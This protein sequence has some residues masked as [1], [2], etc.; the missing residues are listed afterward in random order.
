MQLNR[1]DQYETVADKRLK[2]RA[3]TTEEGAY[4]SRGI[5]TS[6]ESSLEKTK[7]DP[8]LEYVL[9]LFCTTQ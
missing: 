9:D 4:S 2:V 8:A 7:Y 5:P 3:R 6:P 1:R